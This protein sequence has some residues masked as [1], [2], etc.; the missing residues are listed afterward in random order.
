MMM[1][2]IAACV[3]AGCA[4]GLADLPGPAAAAL[5]KQS[6]GNELSGFEAE[7]ANGVAL[8]E[9]AWTE[10]GVEHEAKVTADGDLVELEQ[11]I[12]ASDA[13]ATV[14]AAVAKAFGDGARVRYVKK[15]W[16]V[17]EVEGKVG[18]RHREV[19]YTPTGATTREID[20]DD[21]DDGDDDDDDDVDDDDGGGDD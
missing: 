6:G 20:D 8:Y 9:A 3:V 16:I 15:T 1:M 18:G 12:P 5:K 14:R 19:I 2:A 21:G 7:R 10:G 17:Y 4:G 13:P 11:A